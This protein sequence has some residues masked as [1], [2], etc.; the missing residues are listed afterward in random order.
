MK[1]RI[2]RIIIHYC[3]GSQA[4]FASAVGI[5][6]QYANRIAS[7]HGCGL[8]TVESILTAFPDV[9][10]RWL[11]CGTGAMSI[12]DSIEGECLAALKKIQAVI[13]DD[14]L[15]DEDCFEKIERIVC[16]LEARGIDCGGRH[17]FG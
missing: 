17:D 1:E 10:A 9:N 13:R 6:P 3:G 12:N 11:I 16:E 8:R 14:S 2:K 4:A 15:T 5:T 7:G